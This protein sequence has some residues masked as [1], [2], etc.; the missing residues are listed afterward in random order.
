MARPSFSIESIEAQVGKIPVFSLT[1]R[2]AGLKLPVIYAWA[3]R[4]QVN[5]SQVI[6]CRVDFPKAQT[7]RDWKSGDLVTRSGF[8]AVCAKRFAVTSAGVF[9]SASSLIRRLLPPIHF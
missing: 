1:I 5:W 3:D 6:R 9:Y 8:K 2:Y 4:A 7:F